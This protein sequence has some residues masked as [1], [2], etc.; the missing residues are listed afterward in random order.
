MSEI[1]FYSEQEKQIL[2]YYQEARK[3]ALKY[4]NEILKYQPQGEMSSNIKQSLINE[5]GVA[6]D[7]TDFIDL[8]IRNLILNENVLTTQMGNVVNYY[9]KYKE[10]KQ[11]SK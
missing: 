4:I 8:I 9:F 3:F 5:N 2:N 10:Q 1:F 7:N 11:K 6:A